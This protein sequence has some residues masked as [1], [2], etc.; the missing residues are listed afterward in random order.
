MECRRHYQMIVT[1]VSGQKRKR[2]QPEEV[3]LNISTPPVVHYSVIKGKPG[4]LL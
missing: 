3:S 2:R 4:K 1:G